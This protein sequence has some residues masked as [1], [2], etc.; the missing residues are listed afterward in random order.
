MLTLWQR[1]GLFCSAPPCSHGCNSPITGGGREEGLYNCSRVAWFGFKMAAW[2]TMCGISTIHRPP[3]QGIGSQG[4]RSHAD[5]KFTHSYLVTRRR[6]Q[7]SAVILKVFEPQVQSDT[8]KN[9]RWSIV[10]RETCYS[11]C[12]L[13]ETQLLLFTMIYKNKTS[14]ITSK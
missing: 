10:A 1:H 5:L 12:C 3:C 2:P 8:Q 13:R 14:I 6:V 7:Q 11:T 4:C 9:G